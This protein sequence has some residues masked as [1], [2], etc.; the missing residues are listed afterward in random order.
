MLVDQKCVGDYLDIFFHVFLSLYKHGM[1]VFS[2]EIVIIK[3]IISIVLTTIDSA[4]DF[5]TRPRKILF[6]LK[7]KNET[8]VPSVPR[9]RTYP[10]FRF[11]YPS[12][13]LRIF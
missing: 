5:R 11:A 4:S 12:K 7:S 6:I 10:S 13:A 1:R 2:I 3:S 9:I 8:A